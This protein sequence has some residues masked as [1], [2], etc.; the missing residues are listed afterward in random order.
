M[1]SGSCLCGGIRFEIDRAVGPF[2][3][4]HCLRCRKASGSAFAALVGVRSAAFRL[5]E[6]RELIACYEAPLLEKPPP[7]RVFFCRRCGS[8]APDPDPAPPW[9]ELPAGLLEGDP[10][11]RPDKHIFVEHEPPWLESRD[12]LPR[13]TKA[14][15]AEWRRRQARS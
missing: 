13:F 9:F 5:V 1:I 11:V 8:P 6:G 10:G 3:L 2:E 4:C 14:E 15:L 12:A 7:Y